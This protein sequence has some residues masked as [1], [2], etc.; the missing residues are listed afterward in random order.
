M[1]EFMQEV[2]AVLSYRVVTV[3]CGTLII[4]L[5]YV[6]FRVGIFEKAGELKGVWGDKRLVLKQGAP[7]TF[8]VVFGAIIISISIWKGVDLETIRSKTANE[9]ISHPA[10][11]VGQNPLG[12]PTTVPPFS[13]GYPMQRDV[14]IVLEKAASGDE[15]T[16]EDRKLLSEWNDSAKQF[17]DKVR[18]RLKAWRS[19]IK[20]YSRPWIIDDVKG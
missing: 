4:Y 11:L 9:P 5:G 15:L 2:V 6:L 20:D 16:D 3:T 14:R 13:M 17:E 7:G 18:K 10:G 1:T 12:F 19:P 8:F